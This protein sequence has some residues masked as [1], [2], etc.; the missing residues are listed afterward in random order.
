VPVPVAGTGHYVFILSR[1]NPSHV[2]FRVVESNS[3]YHGYQLELVTGFERPNPKRD[4]E[5]AR[6]IMAAAY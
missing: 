4:I 5:K 2:L 3:S 6:T 1:L